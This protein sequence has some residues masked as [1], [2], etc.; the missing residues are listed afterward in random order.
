M[1][2]MADKQLIRNNLQ[3]LTD[4]AEKNFYRHF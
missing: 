4:D 1:D 3:Q 2:S